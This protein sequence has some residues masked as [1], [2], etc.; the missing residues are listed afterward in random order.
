MY[1][2]GYTTFLYPYYSYPWD[3]LC[4]LLKVSL[5]LPAAGAAGAAAIVAG[6]MHVCTIDHARCMIIMHEPAPL[7]FCSCSQYKRQR[8]KMIG[9]PQYKNM[10]T[11]GPDF[12]LKALPNQ[13]PFFSADF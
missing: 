7:F 11:L 6:C 3:M 2:Y 9:Q 13:D 5:L 12:L 10:T 4:L 1:G 8:R